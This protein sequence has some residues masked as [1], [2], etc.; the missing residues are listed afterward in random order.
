MAINT[1]HCIINMIYNIVIVLINY[2]KTILQG[3]QNVS[4]LT[5]R[6]LKIIPTIRPFY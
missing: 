5:N 6:K 4:N 1:V 3:V 2:T